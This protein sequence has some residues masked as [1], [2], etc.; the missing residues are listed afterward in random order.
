M[1]G[2]ADKM[3]R[4]GYKSITVKQHVYEYFYNEYSKVK[5]EYAIKGVNSFS[6]YVS[7]RLSELLEQEK[8]RSP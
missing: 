1:M 6:G 5:E 7:Y 3:P 4:K 2:T 8:K